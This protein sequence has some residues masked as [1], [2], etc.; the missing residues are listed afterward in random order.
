MHSFS[1]SKQI[2]QFEKLTLRF[3]QFC[4]CEIIKSGGRKEREGREGGDLKN[5]KLVRKANSLRVATNDLSKFNS[6]CI[7]IE[8][9]TT[10]SFWTRRRQQ[11]KQRKKNY[12][13]ENNVHTRSRQERQKWKLEKKYEERNKELKAT[14]WEREI[15]QRE[16]RPSNK[17][18]IN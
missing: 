3:N 1:R 17:M 9:S 8:L 6:N 10:L 12:S 18:T 2:I 5:G 16:Q 14:N 7:G 11:R 4:L 13:K 15:K